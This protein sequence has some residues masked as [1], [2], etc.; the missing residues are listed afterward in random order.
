[1]KTSVCSLFALLLSF[2]LFSENP[3]GGVKTPG[4]VWHG[5]LFAACLCP[6]S[7]IVYPERNSF[8]Y[9][10]CCYAVNFVSNDRSKSRIVNSEMFACY[11]RVEGVL[12]PHRTWYTQ[13]DIDCLIAH[14]M[15]GDRV[16]EKYSE[17]EGGVFFRFV[18]LDEEDAYGLELAVARQYE[19]GDNGVYYCGN[20]KEL[21]SFESN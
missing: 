20:M 1:M 2:P 21:M 7:N 9:K 5:D 10:K 13:N 14:L 6:R 3:G 18:Y 16:F 8:F 19:N 15:D 12:F 11:E 4:A 17:H